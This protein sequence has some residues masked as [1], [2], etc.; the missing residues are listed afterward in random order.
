MPEKPSHAVQL[1]AAKICRRSGAEPFVNNGS[2]IGFDLLGFWQWSA[3]DLLSNA[4]RGILAEYLVARALGLPDNA[5]RN[6][7]DPFDLRWAMEDRTVKI[8][9]KSAAF[10]QSWAQ[11][12]LTKIQFIVGKKHAWD[13][14]SGTFSK[15]ATRT[16][17]VYVF[18]VL[19][20]QDKKTVDPLDLNQWRFWVL[21]TD[22]LN[23]RN[24]SQH[25]IT[26]RSLTGL[27]GDGWS[28]DELADAVR[29]A[30]AMDSPARSDASVPP[31]AS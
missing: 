20:H 12:E 5:I 9:V 13:E 22:V 10:L 30:A 29:Q 15:E 17:D 28:F 1:P 24:R 27:A 8:E 11:K 16:A 6:E 3:S 19:V 26:F 4:T 21:P 25:S 14:D 18:A 31:H 2:S 7:W 23:E